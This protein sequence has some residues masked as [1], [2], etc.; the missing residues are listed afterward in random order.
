MV[1]AV[2]RIIQQ[3]RRCHSRKNF[4]LASGLATESRLH[5]GCGILGMGEGF[6]L[7]KAGKRR[8]GGEIKQEAQQSE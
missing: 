4:Y 2:A 3:W 8:K 1:I 6:W 5:H 7:G